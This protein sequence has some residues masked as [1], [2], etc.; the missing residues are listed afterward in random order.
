MK[1]E[2]SRATQSVLNLTALKVNRY[3]LGEVF[4]GNG[5]QNDAILKCLE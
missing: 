2:N 1:R 4:N 5:F 3:V